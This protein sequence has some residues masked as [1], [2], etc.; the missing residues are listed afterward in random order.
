MTG[1]PPRRVREWFPT[2]DA[3][4]QLQ[5]RRR[6]HVPGQLNLKSCELLHPD[7]ERWHADALGRL[8][9]GAVV[10]YPLAGPA[11]DA[12]AAHFG[13]DPGRVLLT[14]GSDHAVQ[15]VAEALAAPSGRLVVARPHFDG[16]TTC[17]TRFGFRLDGVD[18]PHRAPQGVAPLVERLLAGAPGVL[19]LTQPDSI[20]GHLYTAGEL[21]R[22]V[23]AAH[24][25][26]SVVVVDTCY[27]AYA[28]GG[29]ATVRALPEWDNALRINSFSKSHGL[30]GA[31]LGAVLGE[32][33]MIDYLARWSPDGPLSHVGLALLERALAEP[34]VFR[35]AR[36][37]V[38]T[39]RAELAAAVERT[40]P[41]WSARPTAANF[42]AF[43]AEPEEAG[44]VYTALLDAGIRTRLLNGEP[45]F[46]GGLRVATP[47][48][49]AVAR[50][51][52]V[53]AGLPA[54]TRS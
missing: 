16:W 22:A 44:R 45:G 10:E 28:E 43:D 3:M 48:R 7:V 8:R 49:S 13:Q 39:A 27:L 20:T 41:G 51:T 25:H 35:A 30:A 54:R 19:V 4:W 9:P 21:E 34:A 29:E 2:A 52:D 36:A 23:A 46:S 31:R 47:S 18:L 50:V 40:L 11:T 24:G 38:R 5:P 14:P 1:A 37:E 42:V 33:S 15:L 12:V 26:G 17:A 6:R 53:L 32:E